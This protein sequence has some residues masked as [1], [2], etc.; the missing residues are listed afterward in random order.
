M[1]QLVKRMMIHRE[2]ILGFWGERKSVSVHVHG[3]QEREL[4]MVTIGDVH[5]VKASSRGDLSDE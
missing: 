3:W 5:L 2:S 4:L 1:N